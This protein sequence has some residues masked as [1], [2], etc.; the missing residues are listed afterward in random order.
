MLPFSGSDMRRAIS[1]A[2]RNPI[3]WDTEPCIQFNSTDVSEEDVAFTF[4]VGR[5]TG[6]ARS[7]RERRWLGLFF[8]H[9]GVADMFLR[10][11][12]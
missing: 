5:R 10:N 11:V 9:E 7:Q 6:G 12:G 4:R 3:F 8:D 1:V 2:L